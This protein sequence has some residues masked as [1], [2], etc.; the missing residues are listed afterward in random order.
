VCL[1]E[2]ELV[3][4]LQIHPSQ[5]CSVLSLSVGFKTDVKGHICVLDWSEVKQVVK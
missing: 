2:L 4:K 1:R 3:V 5:A